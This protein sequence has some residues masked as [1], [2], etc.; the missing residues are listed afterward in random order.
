MLLR[1]YNRHVAPV[2]QQ[3]GDPLKIRLNNSCIFF[4]ILEDLFAADAIADRFQ[5]LGD[6]I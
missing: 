2:P 3:A 5:G 4:K 1:Q 6:L